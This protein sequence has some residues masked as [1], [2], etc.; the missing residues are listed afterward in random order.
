ME[1]WLSKRVYQIDA[2]Q[3]LHGYTFINEREVVRVRGVE[4]K[5]DTWNYFAFTPTYYNIQ[6]SLPT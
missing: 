6:Y 4:M 3:S 1:D 5:S 2:I